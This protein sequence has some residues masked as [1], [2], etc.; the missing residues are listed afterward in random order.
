MLPLYA[1]EL[2]WSE[3][4]LQTF[5]HT[6]KF[7]KRSLWISANSERN[8]EESSSQKHG[9]KSWEREW[10][11]WIFYTLL[12]L[13]MKQIQQFSCQQWCGSKG[14]IIHFF[15]PFFFL[16]LLSSALCLEALSAVSLMTREEWASIQYGGETLGPSWLTSCSQI[17]GI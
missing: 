2:S 17:S 16:H 10:K 12:S 15:S 1:G 11:K 9:S 4:L 5:A 7:K 6:L 3:H 14:V 13:H 8:W